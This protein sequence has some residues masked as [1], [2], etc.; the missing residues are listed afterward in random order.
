[1]NDEYDNMTRKQAREY[2]RGEPECFD[3]WICSGDAQVIAVESYMDAHVD[4]Q[5]SL[6]KMR[7]TDYAGRTKAQAN[8]WMAVDQALD[9]AYQAYV[10]KW[11]ETN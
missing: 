3:D 11:E 6:N 9:D 4:L 1:M 2:E 10:G 5:E 8:A 7:V